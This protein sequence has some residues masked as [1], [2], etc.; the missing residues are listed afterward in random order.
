MREFGLIGKKLSHSF[1][2]DFFNEKFSREGIKAKYELF[3]LPEISDLKILL[4]EKPD[5]RGLN[6]TIP[7]KEDVLP[8]LDYISKEA[9]EIGAVNV[10]RI[11]KRAN[12][13]FL[14]GFNT[15]AIGFRE[16]LKSFIGGDINSALILGTGGA[17]KAVKYSLDQLGINS[18]LVSREEGKGNLT[19][20][21][22][23][24]EIMKE[25]LL[26]INTTPLGTFPDVES[27]PDI[28]YHLLTSV[29]FCYDLVYN[30]SVTEFMKRSLQFGAKV[31]NGLEMLCLQALAAWDIWYNSPQ[32]EQ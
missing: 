5:L 10:I 20:T 27:C 30:P 21:G 31:K 25:N 6:V 17:S 16:S 24:P 9:K 18:L 3:P 22:I 1:S 4:Q 12:K 13:N 28:P 11:D 32:Q 26:I 19:Y 23:T 2:A 29:H 7:Y 14:S 15:D 8:Y